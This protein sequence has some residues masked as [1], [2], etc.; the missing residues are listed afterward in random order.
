MLAILLRFTDPDFARTTK[1]S[2]TSGLTEIV[3]IM[4]DGLRARAESDPARSP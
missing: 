3:D 2:A 1:T 4:L